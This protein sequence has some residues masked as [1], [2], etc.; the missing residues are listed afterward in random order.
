MTSETPQ[1]GD[2]NMGGLTPRVTKKARTEHHGTSINHS[3]IMH[4][5]YTLHQSL[6]DD[7]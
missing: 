2:S 1:E 4:T 6:N 3:L 7:S 5:H